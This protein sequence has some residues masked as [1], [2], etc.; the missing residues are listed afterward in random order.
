MKAISLLSGG[1]DS[2][3]ATKAVMDQGIDMVAV[4]FTSPFCLCS[5]KQKEGCGRKAAEMAEQLKVE[6]KAI[7]LGEEYLE[8]I[9]NP[10][11]GHGSG[12]NPCIDCRILKFKAA[13]KLMEEIETPQQDIESQKIDKELGN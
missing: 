4:N 11:Y 3:L 9:R 13:K 1:L 12:V 7:S 8:I 10:V 2:T 5:G 6:Y